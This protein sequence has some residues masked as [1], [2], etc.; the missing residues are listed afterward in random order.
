MRVEPV[1]LRVG[2]GASAAV[3]GVL[4][5]LVDPG[6][7]AEL[8]WLTLAVVV[9]AAGVWV[10]WLPSPVLALAVAAPVVLV[11]RSGQ[12]EQMLFL[13][14]LLGLVVAWFETA[15]LRAIT[16]G[17]VCVAAPVVAYALLPPGEHFGALSWVLGVAFAVV[18]G[19]L[20]RRQL[21]LSERLQ[22]AQREL[23]AVAIAEERRR[24]ARDVHDLVGH[25]LAAVL[26]HLTGARHVLR[27]DPDAADAALA[28]A[29][30]AGRRSMAELRSV[31]ALLR[32]GDD[33]G[34]DAPLPGLADVA[35]LAE[36]SGAQLVVEGDVDRP[37]P[38]VGLV[39]YRIVAE[40]LTNARRHAPQARTHVRLAVTDALVTVDVTSLGATAPADDDRP[41]YGLV[42]MRERAE[43]VGGTV[44]AGPSP[45]GW[46]VRAELPC[47]G[48]R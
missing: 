14:A 8:G 7:P 38:A 11:A 13:C 46:R 26:L 43:I 2:L 1:G 17:L 39:A 44:E 30:T 18:S 23:A 31:M 42:G 19:R 47:G 12:L 40:A 21:E 33:S 4:T 35:P 37:E 16:A 34:T 22:E 5:A 48:A 24:I 27:R 29:E 28:E 6:R 32:G 20:V 36:R 15:Q 45:E 9:L 3:V 41:R 25:G 10:P